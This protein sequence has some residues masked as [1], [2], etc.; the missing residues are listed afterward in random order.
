MTAISIA[1]EADHPDPAEQAEPMAT[2]ERRLLLARRL[3]ITAALLAVFFGAVT[4]LIVFFQ[5]FA[6]GA[7]GCGGG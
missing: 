5:P 6:D 4:L 7:G 3:M 2:A 1:Q